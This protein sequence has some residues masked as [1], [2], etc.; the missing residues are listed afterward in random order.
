[1][2]ARRRRSRTTAV[3]AALL[4]A[5]GCTGEEAG[6]RR[7][8]SLATAGTGGIYYPLGGALASRLS[9]LDTARRYTAEVTGGSVENVNRLR[10]GEVDLGMAIGTTVHDARAG[11]GPFDRPVEGLRV[12]APLYPNATHVLAAD[13]PGLRAVGDLRGRRVSVGPPGGGTERVARQLLAVHGLGREEVTEEHLSFAESAAALKDGAIDGAIFSVGY[14]ASSVLEAMTTADV[15]LLPVAAEAVRV[16]TERHPYYF[17]H[18]IPRDAYPG[19]DSDVPTVAVMNWIVAT[20]AL[21][22]SVVRRLLELLADEEERAGLARVNAIARRIDL[23][24]L[25][26]APAPLHPAA[27]AWWEENG[28][29][30]GGR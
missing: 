23:G 29:N 10:R 26:R 17:P 7:F 2:I 28:G 30:G 19:L 9:V 1:M 13:E 18:T 27:A 8:L 12:V 15:R 4:L 20:E 5:S 11:A 24:A 22:G 6:E 14:P 25:P 3:T 16:L 21:P